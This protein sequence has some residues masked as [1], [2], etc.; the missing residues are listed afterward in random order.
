MKRGKDVSFSGLKIRLQVLAT[1]LLP[2]R[3]VMRIWCA[4]QKKPF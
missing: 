3:A 1:K 2:H 4:Q